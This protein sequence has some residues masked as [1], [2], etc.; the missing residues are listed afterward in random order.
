[1]DE[2]SGKAY[3]KQLLN[4]SCD[5]RQSNLIKYCLQSA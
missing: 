3:Q 5:C 4:F 2:I 1:M